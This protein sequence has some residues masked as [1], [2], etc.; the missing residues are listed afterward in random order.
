MRTVPTASNSPESPPTSR[1]F[2][3]VGPSSPVSTLF[4]AAASVA[5]ERLLSATH[6][7]AMA[8][9]VL[10]PRRNSLRGT[11]LALLVALGTQVLVPHQH[12]SPSHDEEICSGHLSDAANPEPSHEGTCPHC[13]AGKRPRFD[14]VRAPECPALALSSLRIDSAAPLVP[15]R[16]PLLAGVAAPRGPPSRQPRV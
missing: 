11:I 9:N 6:R 14:L 1:R 3:T 5:G 4:A 8:M 16:A 10:P 7:N 12:G 13:L 2:P 15:P